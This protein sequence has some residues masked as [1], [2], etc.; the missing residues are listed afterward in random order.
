MPIRRT[1]ARRHGRRGR[2]VC[3]G[4]LLLLAGCATTEKPLGPPTLVPAPQHHATTHQVV[5]DAV[6]ASLGG[7]AVT[8][9][10]LDSGGVG[11]FYAARPGLVSPWPREVW[12]E[13]PPTLFF[14]RV[15]NHTH[16]E[17]QFDPGMARLVT[18][19]GG[20]DLPIPYEEMYMRLSEADNSGP[21]LQALQAT[22]LS[23]FLVVR[24]GGSREGLLLFPAVRPKAKYLV[25]DVGSFFVGGR[26]VPGQFA[27]QVLRKP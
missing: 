3:L 6:V 20:R 22:L 12:T 2:A 19:D 8:V 10:W 27:F 4:A 5:G 13:S 26:P 25:L 17:V 1:A 24:P 23:R 18:Q 21:R 15:R 7:A 14:F 16:E 11:E 9:R